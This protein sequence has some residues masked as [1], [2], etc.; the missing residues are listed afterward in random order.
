MGHMIEIAKTGRATC[1]TC[2]KPVGKGELRFGEETVNAF[3]TSGEM[4][5]RWHHLL[6]AAGSMPDFVKQALGTFQGDIPNR[7][8]VDAAL[9]GALA[10]QASKPKGLPYSEHAPTGRSKCMHC[11]EPIEKDALRVAVVREVMVGAI[12]TKGTGYLHPQCAPEF[13]HD[14]TMLD[15][16]K[17]N[18][19]GLAPLDLEQLARDFA[20]LPV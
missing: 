19:V 13:A 9:Q 10:K 5:F 8:E 14:P 6:C 12:T 17:A 11:E 4:T 18:S 1:R 2:K 15:Q 20:A 7:A 16:I 3:S